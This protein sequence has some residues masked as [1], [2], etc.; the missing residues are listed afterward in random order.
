MLQKYL[1]LLANRTEFNSIRDAYG[2]LICF[3]AI[4][5]VTIESEHVKRETEID[6]LC[7]EAQSIMELYDCLGPNELSCIYDIDVQQDC[8]VLDNLGD[9]SQYS[10]NCLAFAIDTTESRTAEIVA[11]RQVISSFNQSEENILTL[12]YILVPFNDY[13]LF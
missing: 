5:L 12:C 3:E 8:N 13:G 2:K 1:T 7:A 11:A 10:K 6:L 4:H 9:T